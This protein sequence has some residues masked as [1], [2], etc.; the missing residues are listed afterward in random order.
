MNARGLG[1]LHSNERDTRKCPW[2]LREARRH[3]VKAGPGIRL[4]NRDVGRGERASGGV[5]SRE[6]QHRMCWLEQVKKTE[7][8]PGTAEMT[9]TNRVGR[10][11][12][13]SHESDERTALGAPG[14]E[15]D[16]PTGMLVGVRGFEPPAPSSRS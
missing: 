12:R 3:S 7:V 11:E 6:R 9:L 10:G 8:A 5:R 2:A 1:E 16:Y 15:S 13:V 4:P 14:R